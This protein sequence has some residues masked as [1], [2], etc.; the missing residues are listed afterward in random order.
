MFEG[1]NETI[2][3]IARDGAGITKKR[4]NKAEIKINILAIN[5]LK[6]DYENNEKDFDYYENNEMYF[7][8]NF[9]NNRSDD[10][11]FDINTT[12]TINDNFTGLFFV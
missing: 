7:N 9:R 1:E 5:N 6:N 11:Q 10:K 2:Y 4:S 12:T 3:I 8:S